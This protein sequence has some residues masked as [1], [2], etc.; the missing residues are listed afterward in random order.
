VAFSPDGTLLATS[1]R[2]ETARLWDVGTGQAIRTLTGHT[3]SVL[4]VAFSP[5][6]T[7]LASSSGDNTARLWA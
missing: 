1:S 7:L 2:D 3:N 5:D 4:G 6:G